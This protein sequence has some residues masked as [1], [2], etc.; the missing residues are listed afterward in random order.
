M[1]SLQT[2]A[3]EAL[4]ARLREQL[5]P[6]ALHPG[7]AH[8]LRFADALVPTL[9]AGDVAWAHAQLALRAKGELR[10][11]RSGPVQAHGAWSS[12][13]LVCSAFAPWRTDPGALRVAGLGGFATIRLEERLHIPHGGGTPNLDVALDGPGL[14]A[15]VESKLTE[16][17]APSPARAWRPAYRRPAML[18]ALDGGWADVFAAL[19]EERWAPCHL[20]AGQLVRHALSLRSRGAG[21]HLVLLFWEPA[22]G[23][24]H[25]EVEAH[26]HE[27]DELRA[28]LGDDAVPRFHAL[29]YADLL[30]AW[31]PDRPD[32]VAALRAR[33]E[34]SVG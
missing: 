32:H 7:G 23:A 31:E 12:T 14:F 28:R 5:P 29:S 27:L 22:G 6:E 1:S 24:G 17:L 21:A 8:A 15:G 10:P 20:D 30:D 4:A 13:A 26:R 19:L 33:Y 11:A 16:H 25:P 34:V 18:A 9:D 2:R 3:R